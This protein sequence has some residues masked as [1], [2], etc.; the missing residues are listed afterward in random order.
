M[1]RAKS[2]AAASPSATDTDT[3]SDDGLDE[4]L[5]QWKKGDAWVDFAKEDRA[6]LEKGYATVGKKAVFETTK[7]SFN[8]VGT[9]YK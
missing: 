6:V 2:K 3:D 7:L 9:L 1:P 5:W 4:V 8:D